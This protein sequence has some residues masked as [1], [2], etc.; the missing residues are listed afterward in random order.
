MMK[1][2]IPLL[3]AGVLVLGPIGC[4]RTNGPDQPVSANADRTQRSDQSQPAAQPNE[5]PNQAY[6]APEKAVP[7]SP[8]KRADQVRPAKPAQPQRARTETVAS[9]ASVTVT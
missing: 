4:N 7:R 6:R 1:L 2:A 5:Q 9:G 8:E 3:L